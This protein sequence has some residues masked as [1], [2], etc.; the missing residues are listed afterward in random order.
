MDELSQRLFDDP[1]SY[2]RAVELLAR[3]EEVEHLSWTVVEDYLSGLDDAETK[4]LDKA[5]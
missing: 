3:Y 4:L 1:A 5:L 2:S